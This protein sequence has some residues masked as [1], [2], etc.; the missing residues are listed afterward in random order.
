MATKLFLIEADYKSEA[1]NLKFETISNDQ[2]P[3]VRNKKSL[4]NLN[5][6]HSNL[7]RISDFFNSNNLFGSGCARLG[8]LKIKKTNLDVKQK[9]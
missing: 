3:N 1:R 8:R 7:F 9:M 6:E 2:I 5:F 4:G